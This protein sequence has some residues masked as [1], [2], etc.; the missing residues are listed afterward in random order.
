MKQQNWM[1]GGWR[2]LWS[3]LLLWATGSAAVL[4]QCG[5]AAD[6]QSS[7]T[8]AGNPRQFQCTLK[9]MPQAPGVVKVRLQAQ[10]GLFSGQNQIEVP[11]Q[12]GLAAFQF[13]YQEGQFNPNV[14]MMV[15]LLNAAN[16]PV[17]RFP[18]SGVLSACATADCSA[19]AA[20]ISMMGGGPQFVARASLANYRGAAVT[21][22][23]VMH[24]GANSPDLAR[25]TLEVVKAER[26]TNC[27]GGPG[28][29]VAAMVPPAA[30]HLTGWSQSVYATPSLT[31]AV[32]TVNRSI[33]TGYEHGFHLIAPD[34]MN[35]SCPEQYRLHLRV[36]LT[37]A[38]G[39][40]V[41]Q[42]FADLIV[43][44]P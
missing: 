40:E 29:W 15:H 33:R 41:T 16:M 38:N 25:V 3:I 30:P 21:V 32:S 12:N 34:K 9:V 39:C 19:A 42:E 1:I 27:A 22:P 18:Y 44:R 4:G 7:C 36:K 23:L 2:R 14:N 20:T 31:A 26:R 28:A 35:A 37:F 43:S 11:V 8:Q 24:G 10:S 5:S 6:F 17:C 13:T